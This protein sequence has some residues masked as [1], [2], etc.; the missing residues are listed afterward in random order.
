MRVPL[1]WLKD[2]V[3]FDISIDNLAELLTARGVIV[4]QIIKPEKEISGV[5]LGRIVQMEKHPNADRLSL[6]KI[7]TKRGE[8]LDIITGA[9]NVKTGD[10]VPV[11]TVGA[12]LHGGLKISKSKIRGIESFGMLCSANELGLDGKDLPIEQREGVMSLQTDL[13]TGSD[14]VSEF[15]L[16]DPVLVLETFANRPDLLSIIGVA[17]E[18]G[19]LLEKPLKFPDSSFPEDEKP[20]SDYINVK[21][22]D[23]DL[24]PRYMGRIISELKIG[25]SPAMISNRLRLGGMRS[26]NNVVDV[27]N[28]VMLEY[29]QPFHAFD[30]DLLHGKTITVRPAKKGEELLTIDQ[31]KIN[32]NPNMLVIA[33]ESGPVAL[34][35][36]MGGLNSEI[37]Q[38]SKTILLEIANFQPASI[39]RT[40]VNMGMRSESSRRFEKGPDFYGIPGAADRACHLLS[41]MGGKIAKGAVDIH[42]DPPPKVTLSLRPKRTSFTLGISVGK[43]DCTSIL[44]SLDMHVEDNKESIIITVPTFRSDLIREE[45]LIEEIARC[46]GYDKIPTTMPAG[47]TLHGGQGEKEEFREWIADCMKSCGMTEIITPSLHNEQMFEIFNLGKEGSMRITNPIVEDQEWIRTSLLPGMMKAL[48]V[49]MTPSWNRIALFEIS[50]LYLQEMKEAFPLE[51]DY[52]GIIMASSGKDID[53]YHVKGIFEYIFD[54]LKIEVEFNSENYP[55]SNPGVSAEICYGNKTIGNFGKVHPLICQRMDIEI[56]VFFGILDLRHTRKSARKKFYEPVPRFPTIERDLAFIIDENILCS[57]I[58]ESIKNKGGEI[59]KSTICFDQYKGSQ[60]PHG[61]KSLAFRL[62]FSAPDRTLTDEETNTTIDDIIKY[63]KDI[64]KVILREG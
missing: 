26:I 38:N 4:D 29:G 57:E 47:I 41:T 11:A 37:N 43:K 24:C 8:I 48:K 32:L 52:L 22:E 36:V 30:Y 16:N 17:R 62:L 56:P 45:D 19:S 10:L 20:A 53:F 63:L 40:S 15:L 50:K 44:T 18:V 33:D 39:R 59:L 14:L 23:F 5:I 1:S 34:A 3:E 28:Y 54:E 2:Y 21:I 7:E 12:N 51:K 13:P 46:I 58:T 25:P 27:T 31:T 55:W 61:K 60:I 42:G 6:C 35:G 49:N 9:P 64:F